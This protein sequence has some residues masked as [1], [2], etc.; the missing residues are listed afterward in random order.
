MINTEIREEQEE[1]IAMDVSTASDVEVDDD[2]SKDDEVA[3]I[4]YDIS[5]YGAD[6]DAE[7]LVRR[8]QRGDIL[9]PKFQRNYI[10]Q[11]PTA[12]RLIES[13]LL[14]LPIPSVFLAKEPQSNKLIV[15]DGQ[16]RLKTL[17]FFFDGVFNPK[18]EDKLQKTFKLTK[19]QKQFEGCAYKTLMEKDRIR[20]NDAIVH[21]IIIKQESPQDSDTSV[22]HVFERLNTGGRKLQPQELRTAI[23]HGALI[24]FIQTLNS[25]EHW[26]KIFG[27]KHD[28]LKDQELILRFIA[29]YCNVGNYSRPMEEFL[30]KFAKEK[31]NPSSEFCAQIESVFSE[32]MR[33]MWECIGDK[34]FRPEKVLNAAIFDS[35]AVGLARRIAAK[36]FSNCSQFSQK[37]SELLTNVEYRENIDQATSNEDRVDKR[38]SIA[39]DAFAV[40]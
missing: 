5:S 36:N 7:G 38:I 40:L 33:V 13:L 34:S 23:Y 11:L 32:T 21:A 19:V 8:L 15:I 24:D 35:V 31:R 18:P 39:T 6:Y 20:L 9:I 27:R 14:G 22:Y 12:S 25:N 2:A 16:Q 26:R 1:E 28:R 4:S 10:W 17:E 37:Y 29:M 30:N 3:P